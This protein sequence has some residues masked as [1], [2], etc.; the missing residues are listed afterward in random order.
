MT[1]GMGRGAGGDLL[2]CACHD[3]R[4]PLVAGFWADVENP[5]GRLDDI[6]VV[7]DDQQAVAFPDQTVEGLQQH[8]NVVDVE[9]GRGLVKDEKGTARFLSG[10]SGGQFQALGFAAA[11][12]IEGLAEFEIVQTDLG[13]D[14]QGTGDRLR[15]GSSCEELDRLAGGHF[16]HVVDRLPPVPHCQ[17]PLLIALAVALRTAEEEVAEELHLDLLEAESGAAVA[18]ALAGVEGESG[19]SESG[20]QRGILHGK[21]FPDGVEDPQV[22]GRGGAGCPGEGGLVDEDDVRE[23]FPAA[24]RLAEAC[25]LTFLG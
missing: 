20:L 16:E 1:P 4:A 7:L 3:Q 13:E 14:A 18:P 10:E 5:V 22:D 8:R 11:Q 21:E 6:K 24:E 19:G 12:D 25:G 2:G 15:L 17:D 9:A 23:M